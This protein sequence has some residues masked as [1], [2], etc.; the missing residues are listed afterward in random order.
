M[1]RPI[2]AAFEKLLE[3][4]RGDMVRRAVRGCDVGEVGTP[5]G[6]AGRQ[7]SVLTSGNIR[8]CVTGRPAMTASAEATSS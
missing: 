8:W 2:A 4:R 5:L 3:G 6:K 7:Q 1:Q